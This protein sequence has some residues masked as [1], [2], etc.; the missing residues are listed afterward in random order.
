MVTWP[1]ANSS[2]NGDLITFSMVDSN[3]WQIYCLEQAFF[4]TLRKCPCPYRFYALILGLH[5]EANHKKSFLLPVIFPIGWRRF[6]PFPTHNR[7]LTSYSYR[8]SVPPIGG[9][10]FFTMSFHIG[11]DGLER[12][13][14]RPP[15][16]PAPG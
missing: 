5:P 6:W 11:E 8:M 9:L 7:R 16:H 13:V 2:G 3:P 12:G 1:L 10:H 14:V 15:C 4:L